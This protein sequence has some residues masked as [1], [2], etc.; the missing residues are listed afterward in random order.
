MLTGRSG[1]R[2]LSG[3]P[4]SRPVAY[5]SA[6]LAVFSQQTGLVLSSL[7]VL[8]LHPSGQPHEEGSGRPSN[9]QIP[10]EESVESSAA[11][12]DQGHMFGLPGHTPVMRC[13]GHLPKKGSLYLLH[14]FYAGYPVAL[15]PALANVPASHSLAAWPDARRLPGLEAAR[16]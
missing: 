8:S 3:R 14:W 7:Q 11:G 12:G 6:R 5:P 2:E 15:T 13:W 10:G 1:S 4:S 9:S 16:L